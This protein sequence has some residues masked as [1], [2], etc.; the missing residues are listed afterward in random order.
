MSKSIEKGLT[1]L[2]EKNARQP[3]WRVILDNFELVENGLKSGVTSMQF[4]E[5]MEISKSAFSKALN[6]ARMKSKGGQVCNR[7][8]HVVESV[9]VKTESEKTLL[10]SGKPKMN[11]A[12]QS[13]LKNNK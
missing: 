5:V 9:A 4:A 7:P 11:D 13:L 3:A 6:K 8:A 1:E 2:V 12:M 10:P